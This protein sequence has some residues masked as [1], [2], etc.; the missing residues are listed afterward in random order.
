MEF[1]QALMPE[2]RKT[3]KWSLHEIEDFLG[4]IVIPVR[5]ASLTPTGN[6]NV[7][8]LWYFYE[9]GAIWCAT[10]QNARVVTWLENHPNCG[11]EI[12]TES[13][14]YRG[15]RGQGKVTILKEEGPRVLSRL[16]DRYLES[17]DSQFAEWLTSRNE[18][19]VAIRIDPTWMTAWDFTPRMRQGTA[20]F[21]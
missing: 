8:S 14:P 18:S 17:H 1:E 16:I 3:S 4:K 7:C 6:P 21:A 9:G 11:F 15:V 20:G 10:Q 13:M 2:V 12:S 19:E 5:L